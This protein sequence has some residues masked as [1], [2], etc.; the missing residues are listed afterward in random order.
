M[1]PGIPAGLCPKGIMRPIWH[2]LKKCEK[3]LCDAK[4]FTIKANMDCY[5]LC[6]PVMNE[7]FKQITSP[8]AT[9]ELESW[10]HSLKKLTTF[11]KNRCKIFVIK[12]DPIN[13]CQMALLR[14]FRVK[15]QVIPPPGE[16]DPNLITKTPRYCKHHI[17]YSSKVCYIQHKSIINRLGVT[18]PY[19]EPF[20]FWASCKCRDF[21][22]KSALKKLDS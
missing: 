13:N 4:K 5:H 3:T 12:Y 10:E 6:L 11:K 9:T 21:S 7:Y 8:K 1:F 16:R 14:T 17:N 18:V 22:E 20:Y 19:M 15:V 2:G